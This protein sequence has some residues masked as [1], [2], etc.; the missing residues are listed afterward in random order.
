MH[1]A[2]LKLLSHLYLKHE[3][4]TRL[5]LRGEFILPR[6]ECLT[7]IPLNK[8]DFSGNEFSGL[9]RCTPYRRGKTSHQNS[10]LSTI[11][12]NVS[13]SFSELGSPC[14]LPMKGVRDMVLDR[15]EK[16][17]NKDYYKMQLLPSKTYSAMFVPVIEAVDNLL[18]L[19]EL[20]TESDLQRLLHIL[21]PLLFPYPQ[22]SSK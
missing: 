6:S 7:P 4:Q 18:V 20:K 15:L 16:M 2:F 14:S 9:T 8:P 3:I 12:H 10:L 17:L 21:D 1:A 13:S 11:H 19:G 5:L 22:C